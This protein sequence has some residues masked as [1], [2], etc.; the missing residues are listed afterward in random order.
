MK[1]PIYRSNLT[2]GHLDNYEVY[3][4][5]ADGVKKPHKANVFLSSDT[6][7]VT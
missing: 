5:P 6:K 3:E 2:T 1:S 7:K 4:S